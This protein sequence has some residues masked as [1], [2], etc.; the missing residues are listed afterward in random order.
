M[1]A[2][3]RRR[4]DVRPS[5]SGLLQR[6]IRPRGNAAAR[7][8]GRS[9]WDNRR[10]RPMGDGD[11][12][13]RREALHLVTTRWSQAPACPTSSHLSTGSMMNGFCHSATLEYRNPWLVDRLRWEPT[14]YDR[15]EPGHWMCHNAIKRPAPF[16]LGRIPRPDGDSESVGRG[17]A[18]HGQLTLIVFEWNQFGP[19]KSDWGG[20]PRSTGRCAAP[21]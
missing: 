17:C 3:T 6:G 19:P 10:V 12:V 18:C 8:S 1:I 5:P 7:R 14:V 4:V 16:F 15:H 2:P 20:E 11:T 9:S 21:K 13:S